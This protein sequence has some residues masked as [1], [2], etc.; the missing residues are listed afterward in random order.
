[1]KQ[2]L[3]RWFDEFG[4]ALRGLL[5]AT[6]QKSFWLPFTLTIVIFGVVINLLSSGFTSF[7][8]IGAS[9]AGGDLT[10]G[11][12]IIL[13]AFLAIFGVGKSF[14]DWFLNFILIL[15][16][17]VLVA[18]VVF[19]AKHNKNSK[20][21]KKT[22]DTKDSADGLESSAL[23]A[24]LV[25]LGSGCPTCGTTLLAPILG[26]ILSGTSGAVA[27]AGKLS[28]ALNLAAIILAIFVFKKLGFTTY[29][30][31]KSEKYKRK[32]EARE[33]HS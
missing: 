9:V 20:K 11:L 10:A 4:L 8:L 30:I 22:A 25:V 28:L 3:L 6:K 13:D 26:A 17:S 33:T 21:S 27:L 32:Q 19:V 24:G 18:L 16:Q 5:L 29:A 14:G 1:M 2:K 12:K 23:V 7:R 31:I 15:F